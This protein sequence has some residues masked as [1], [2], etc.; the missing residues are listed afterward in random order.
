MGVQKHSVHDVMYKVCTSSAEAVCRYAK[1]SGD[2]RETMPEYFMPAFIL[3][4]LGSK[5][6]MTL[7]TNSA[8]LRNWDKEA[9][10]RRSR[11]SGRVDGATTT[12]LEQAIKKLDRRGR[13]DLVVFDGS[14]RVKS[15]E[16][17]LILVEFKLWARDRAGYDR[18]KLQEVL[19]YIQTCPYGAICYLIDGAP[20]SEWVRDLKREAGRRKDKWF[21]APVP[22]VLN[23]GKGVFSVC[24]ELFAREQ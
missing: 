15:D 3:E 7:E 9:Q 19:S 24:A 17:F 11:S 12:R 5:I 6:T 8:T 16:E 18:D 13:I 21:C 14:S 22:D 23:E 2:S 1:V 4:K 20:D 10:S